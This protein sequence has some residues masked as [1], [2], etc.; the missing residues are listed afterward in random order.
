MFR[1]LSL[2]FIPVISDNFAQ[3]LYILYQ[4][5]IAKD[6]WRILIAQHNKKEKLTNINLLTKNKQ[7]KSRKKKHFFFALR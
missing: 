3:N 7:A 5:E 2:C 1:T 6:K 4:N